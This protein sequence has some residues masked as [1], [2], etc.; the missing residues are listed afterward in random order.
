MCVRAAVYL[1]FYA[2]YAISSL[3]AGRVLH[4]MWCANACL[5]ARQEEREL[6]RLEEQMRL[7]E[8]ERQ[9]RGAEIRRL[10]ENQQTRDTRRARECIVCMEASPEVVFVPCGHLVCCVACA[11]QVESCPS[12]RAEIAQRVRTYLDD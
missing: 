11:E 6:R 3:D 5:L 12:C 4:A 2:V 8:A 1:L 10:K 9:R 7:L